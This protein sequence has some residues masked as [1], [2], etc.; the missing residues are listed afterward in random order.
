MR[1]KDVAVFQKKNLVFLQTDKPA[2]FSV[3]VIE[4]AVQ[5]LCVKWQRHNVKECL[6][7]QVGIGASLDLRNP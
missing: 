5:C 7:K 1:V 2:E 4:S 3:R 6:L